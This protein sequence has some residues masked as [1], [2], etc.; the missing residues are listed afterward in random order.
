MR[1]TVIH[2]E[3]VLQIN[4]GRNSPIAVYTKGIKTSASLAEIII[5]ENTVMKNPYTIK[6]ENNFWKE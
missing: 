3:I 5:R 2:D 1:G 6:K 4:R